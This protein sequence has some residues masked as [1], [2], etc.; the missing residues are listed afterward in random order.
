[1][2]SDEDPKPSG[3]SSGEGGTTSNGVVDRVVSR[4]LEDAG[5]FSHE[6][7]EKACQEQPKCAAAIRDQFAALRR[8]GLLGAIFEEGTS[9]GKDGGGEAGLEPVGP[10]QPLKELGRGGQAVVYLAEDLRLHRPVALKV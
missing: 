6:V 4:C 1:M 7:I 10:Y 8:A 3:S 9:T 2:R 5:R